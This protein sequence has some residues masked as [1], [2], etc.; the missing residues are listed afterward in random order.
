MTTSTELRKTTVLVLGMHRSG[1]SAVAAGLEQ[2]GVVMGSALFKGDE[3]NPKGYFEEQKIVELNNRLLEQRGLRWDSAYP[4][5]HETADG[6]LHERAEASALLNDIFGNAPVWGFKDPRMCLLSSFWLPTLASMQVA[7]HLLLMLRDPSEVAISLARRDGISTQRAG[8]L[9]FNHLLGSLDYVEEQSA[10]WLIDFSTLL[11]D[12]AGVLRDLG[13]WLGLPSDEEV[14]TRFASDFI[15]PELSHGTSR[16]K[17]EMHPLVARAYTFWCRIAAE[18]CPVF[19]A[20]KDPEWLEIR[21]I[22]ELEIKPHLIAVQRFFEG[23]RQLA[24]MDSRLVSL[25]QALQ[26][27]ERLAIDRLEQM[28]AMDGQLKQTSD[29]LAFAEGLAFERLSTIEQMSAELQR[30]TTDQSNTKTF[31]VERLDAIKKLRR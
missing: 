28:S 16:A 6:Q 5:T 4:V 11:R 12:P 9:W 29:A 17:P 26:V 10:T 19:S 22:F 13:H 20:L 8:W 18:G 24:V 15:S 2:L 23:D 21:Q 27:T 14:V 25:S 31:L 1:T 3:W 7:P 30:Q